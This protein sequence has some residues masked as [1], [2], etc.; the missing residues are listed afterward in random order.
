MSPVRAFPPASP[1][2]LTR[3]LVL[4]AR[5]TL[6]ASLLVGRDAL[7]AHETHWRFRGQLELILLNPWGIYDGL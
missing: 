7:K 1:A 2:Y 5:L 4:S 6:I 3:P